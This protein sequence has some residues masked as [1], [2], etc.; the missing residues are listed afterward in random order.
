[1]ALVSHV[2]VPHSQCPC[3]TGHLEHTPS[4]RTLTQDASFTPWK[5]GGQVDDS[6]QLTR[7]ESSMIPL[8]TR[9]VRKKTESTLLSY[10]RQ[11]L[12]RPARL[13]STPTKRVT[14]PLLR[15]SRTA[16][17]TP[18]CFLL[19]CPNRRQDRRS[20][21]RSFPENLITCIIACTPHVTHHV[22]SS[23]DSRLSHFHEVSELLS[24][25][26]PVSIRKTYSHMHNSRAAQ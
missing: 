10:S 9:A 1:M 13:H 12:S 6:E 18:I 2:R 7:L 20:L 8:S 16:L 11:C 5:I 25:P 23:C 3:H 22:Q 15:T 14:K 17:D 21:R 24:Q 4:T 26:P 19:R